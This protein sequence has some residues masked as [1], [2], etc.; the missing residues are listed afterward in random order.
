[1]TKPTCSEPGYN[2]VSTTIHQPQAEKTDWEKM[3]ERNTDRITSN[4]CRETE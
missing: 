2:L 1:M 3:D 4:L